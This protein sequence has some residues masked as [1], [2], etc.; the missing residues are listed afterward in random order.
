[1]KF[2]TIVSIKDSA[3]LVPPTVVRQLL[4][5][6][7]AWVEEQKRAG[8]ILEIYSLAGWARV[9]SISEHRSAEDLDQF[10]SPM[11]AFLNFETYPLADFGQAMKASIEA[12]K[13]AE[14]LFPAAPK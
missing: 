7:V 11:D 9:V 8:K 12:A 1:M 14:A 13:V 6:Q 5:A 10:L 2:I 3:A 4:E